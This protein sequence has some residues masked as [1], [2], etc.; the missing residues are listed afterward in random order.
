MSTFTA[1]L[2]AALDDSDS[3]QDEVA[4]PKS[5]PKHFK[6]HAHAFIRHDSCFLNPCRPRLYTIPT[7]KPRFSV[8]AITRGELLHIARR[9]NMSRPEIALRREIFYQERYL[10]SHKAHG[11]TRAYRQMAVALTRNRRHLMMLKRRGVGWRDL[12]EGV[13]RWIWDIVRRIEEEEEER[14][15]EDADENAL[16]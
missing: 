13:K 5:H 14:R 9:R 12:P 1:D 16:V 11:G 4:G 8:P 3:E 15:M 10:I 7:P 6:P 2:R